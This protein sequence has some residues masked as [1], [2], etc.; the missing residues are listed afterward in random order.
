MDRALQLT[1]PSLLLLGG[2]LV[3]GVAR[4]DQTEE[5]SS[6]SSSPIEYV[7]FIVKENHTFDNYFATYPGADGSTTAKDSKGRT[8]T[9]GKPFTD[10][11]VPGW[12]T[13]EWAHVDHDGGAM[14]HF[15]LGEE[16]DNLLGRV[17]SPIMNGPFVTYS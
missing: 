3:S 9:L 13:W 10:H 6:R 16:K 4:S 8:R 7:F 1:L 5:P 14:D 15:D 11:D 2:A 12:N 17:L